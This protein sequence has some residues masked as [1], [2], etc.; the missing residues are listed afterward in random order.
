[1]D[2]KSKQLF[3]LIGEHEL[4]EVFEEK[5]EEA[6][7][8]GEKRAKERI[9]EKL[10]KFSEVDLSIVYHG[11]LINGERFLAVIEE[12]IEGSR[13]GDERALLGRILEKYGFEA[14]LLMAI[15]ESGELVQAAAK[16]LG[17][18]EQSP[19][20]LIAELAD[21]SLM[22]DQMRLRWDEEIEEVRKEKLAR[23]KGRLEFDEEKESKRGEEE[24]I[25]VK[26]APKKSFEIPLKIG[27][28]S[29]LIGA[30]LQEED[31]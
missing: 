10:D 17:G 30:V 18:R 19:K 2:S 8:E 7:Q 15:E 5:L 13:A 14:Q 29:S 21:V 28:E 16:F 26:L 4:V 9:K 12:K 27:K 23:I 22:V 6:Q 20:N 11:D 25:T 1:M 31:R 3:E 24:Q